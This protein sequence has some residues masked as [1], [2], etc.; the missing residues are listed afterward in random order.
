MDT[1]AGQNLD[2]LVTHDS[3]EDFLEVVRFVIDVKDG[4]LQGGS[5]LDEVH[6]LRDDTLLEV[7][8][9]YIRLQLRPK[10]SLGRS[11]AG[12]DVVRDA[13]AIEQVTAVEKLL[14]GMEFGA[15]DTFAM[16][17]SMLACG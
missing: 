11:E 2:W 8:L 13:E 14:L 17:A 7:V 16:G 10:V 3:I 1:E 6:W 15:R 4:A 9:S 5:I 12:F